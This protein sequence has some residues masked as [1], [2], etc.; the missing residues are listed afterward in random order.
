MVEAQGG[1]LEAVKDPKSYPAAKHKIEVTSTRSGHVS[2]ID[3]LAVGLVGVDLGAG[4]QFVEDD[5]DFSAGIELLKKTGD[6]VSEGDVLAIL[7]TNRDGVGQVGAQKVEGA[8]KVDEA[9]PTPRQLI[10]NI[11]RKGGLV[12]AFDSSLLK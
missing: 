1:S 9:V 2:A 12:E 7:S 11:V 5:V 3:A 10:T 4:R 8:Y 6:K